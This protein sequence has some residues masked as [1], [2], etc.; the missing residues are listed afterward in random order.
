MKTI[1]AP[2]ILSADFAHLAQDCESVLA[3]GA[4]WL[5][6]D[7]M[8]QHF[9]PNLSFGPPVIKSLRNHF[10]SSVYF[11]VHLMI[12]EPEK[13]VDVTLTLEQTV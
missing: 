9:V 12:T 5:H 3:S 4:D 8:D 6:I 7:I 10:T 2:S 1:I 13:W 11:D